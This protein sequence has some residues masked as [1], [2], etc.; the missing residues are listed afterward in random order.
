MDYSYSTNKNLLELKINKN[1][2]LELKQYKKYFDVLYYK[3]CQLDNNI[4]ELKEYKN[5][6][7]PEIVLLYLDIKNNHN[8]LDNNITSKMDKIKYYAKLYSFK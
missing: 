1:K 3:I 5:I 2:L 6:I 4:I 7:Y 8:K